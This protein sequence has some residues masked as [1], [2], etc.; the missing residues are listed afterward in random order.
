M[1]G[2]AFGEK[3]CYFDVETT[4]TD[5]VKNGVWSIAALYEYQGTPVDT[6]YGEV[7]IFP[8]DEIHPDALAMSG[9][10]E[11]ELRSL[12]QP[13]EVYQGFIGWLS[14]YVSKYDSSDKM[15]MVAYNAIFDDDFAREW[16][17]KLHNGNHGYYGSWFHGYRVYLYHRMQ[18]LAHEKKIVLP[19]YKQ[20][21][22]CEHFGIKYL[23]HHALEDVKA[24]RRLYYKI[25][26]FPDEIL[27]ENENL[28]GVPITSIVLPGAVIPI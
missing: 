11:G 7:A 12:R 17:K 10:T 15:T 25:K 9:K 13:Y 8:E 2:G 21:V 27:P 6:F 18:W 5:K 26:D 19:K 16:F 22:V 20:E 23:A 1:M 4:G 3:L 14:K 28:E 24:S